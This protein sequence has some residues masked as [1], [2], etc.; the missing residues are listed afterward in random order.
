MVVARSG[1]GSELLALN[2][3]AASPI[4]SGR[5]AF[6]E[7]FNVSLAL[8]IQSQGSNDESPQ[9][10]F[11]CDTSV[12]QQAIVGEATFFLASDDAGPFEHSNVFGNVV[13]SFLQ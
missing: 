8:L 4:D 13:L 1:L 6:G 3:D 9:G 10:D 12:G 7:A 11:S 5:D 2:A